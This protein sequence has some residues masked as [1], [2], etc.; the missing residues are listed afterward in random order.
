MSE[1]GLTNIS[2]KKINKS[3]GLQKPLIN[4]SRG[5]S[6]LKPAYCLMIFRHGLRGFTRKNNKENP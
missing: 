1:K 4:Q 2:L 5:M 3:K 6:I